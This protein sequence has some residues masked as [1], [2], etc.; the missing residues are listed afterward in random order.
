[1]LVPERHAMTAKATLQR[2]AKRRIGTVIPAQ[3][4]MMTAQGDQIT[5]RELEM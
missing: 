4:N 2:E 1:V 5:L 3:I